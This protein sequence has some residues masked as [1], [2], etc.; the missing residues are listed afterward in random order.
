MCSAS[1]KNFHFRMAEA[2]VISV[3]VIGKAVPANFIAF[4]FLIYKQNQPCLSTAVNHA[5]KHNGAPQYLA[6]AMPKNRR[7]PEDVLETIRL[8]H[9]SQ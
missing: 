5:I 1:K 9:I 6:C 3:P 2:E 7:R 4:V 8:Y